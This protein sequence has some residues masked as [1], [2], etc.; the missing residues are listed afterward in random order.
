MLS[1]SNLFFNYSCMKLKV[2]SIAIALSLAVASCGNKDIAHDDSHDHHEGHE[3]ESAH[4]ED[5][6]EHDYDHESHEHSDGEIELSAEKA[7]QFGIETTPVKID[8]IYNVIKVAGETTSDP[9]ATAIATAPYSG[10][11]NFSMS[12]VEGKKVA[13][14]AQLA[15]IST[16]GIAGADAISAA[17]I[18]YENALREVN[19]L[20]ELLSE[21]LTTRAEYNSALSAMELARNAV[22]NTNRIITSPIAGTIKNVDV[23]NGQ[24]VETGTPIATIVADGSMVVRA[25][26]PK[27]YV[28]MV[29]SISGATIKEPYTGDTFDVSLLAQPSG[30]TATSGYIPVYFNLPQTAKLAPGSYLEVY[31]SAGTN[32]RG[33]SIP[34]EALSD[35]LG[36]KFVYVKLSDDHYERRPV[37]IGT[38]NAANAE[39]ISGL[40]EG[41]NVVTNGVT[42]LR[43]AENAN[44]A[45]PGH[46]HNH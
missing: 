25:D 5:E 39:I 16:T 17:K 38:V 45:V 13:K 3:T 31:I 30:S 44:V 19:R 12:L 43:L 18:E 10:N 22:S 36:Q 33:V 24:Y 42:F 28:N 37:A 6:H 29:S 14:G 2:Y 15:T 40:R 4:E 8:Y 27:R 26:L 20:K 23:M 9:R 46:T 35:K 34:T 7:K 21:G 11:V 1:E 32:R 41:E